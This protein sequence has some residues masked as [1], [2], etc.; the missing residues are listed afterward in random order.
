M[1]HSAQGKSA[2]PSYSIVLG[3]PLNRIYRRVALVDS[4]MGLANRRVVTYALISWLPLFL[5]SAF[6]GR[7][8]KGVQVPFMYDPAV[9]LRLLVS[10][11]LLIMGEVLVH[12]RLD[13]ILNQFRIRRIVALKNV[14]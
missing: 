9:H 14:P 5:L 4:A 12:N 7:L 6:A 13:K 10:I 3:G 2:V 11:P 1:D 8:V